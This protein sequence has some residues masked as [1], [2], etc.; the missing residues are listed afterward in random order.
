[1]QA[2]TYHNVIQ[3]CQVMT[4]VSNGQTGCIFAKGHIPPVM[5]STLNAQYWRISESSL[6]GLAL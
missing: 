1:M 2:Q 4:S 5:Q 3:E 6:A